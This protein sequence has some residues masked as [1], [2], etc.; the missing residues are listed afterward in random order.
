MSYMVPTLKVWSTNNLCTLMLYVTRF[1]YILHYSSW[2]WLPVTSH[3]SI[4][5]NVILFMIVLAVCHAILSSLYENQHPLWAGPWFN[6]KM[7]SYQYRKFHC[8]DKTV[9]RS[10]YLHNGISYTDK[11]TSLYWISPLFW[12]WTCSRLAIFSAIVCLGG[13]HTV[14][15]GSCMFNYS[16]KRSLNRSLGDVQWSAH[17]MS[18]TAL[19]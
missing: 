6:I 5:A 3:K 8:G 9:V 17:L 18:P 12:T 15:T 11:M 1:V 16:L 13:S 4:L 14:Q 2:H 10:S 7:S 19:G